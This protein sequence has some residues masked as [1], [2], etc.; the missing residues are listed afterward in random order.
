MSV[1]S[2]VRVFKCVCWGRGGGASKPVSRVS[3][4]ARVCMCMCVVC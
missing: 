2:C 3:A 1:R 4:R